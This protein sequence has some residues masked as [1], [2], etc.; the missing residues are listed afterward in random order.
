M[1]SK[2]SDIEKFEM[3]WGK[4]PMFFIAIFFVGGIVIS[5]YIDFDLL[6]LLFFT[7][8]YFIFIFWLEKKWWVS[9]NLLFYKGLA[10]S[11]GILLVGTLR[12]EIDKPIHS[13]YHVLNIIDHNE[14]NI[15]ISGLVTQI[16]QSAKSWKVFVN[17][18]EICQK[19]C[20]KKKTKTIVY[21]Q[22]DHDL[23]VLD[24]VTFRGSILPKRPPNFKAFD[25]NQYLERQGIYFTL[26]VKASTISIQKEGVGNKVKNFVPAFKA[27]LIANIEKSI[28]NTLIQALCKAMFLGDR[29]DVDDDTI[30][31]FSHTGA[32]HILAVSGLH[33]AII[34]GFFVWLLSLVKI[35][36]PW[37]N[38][39][40]KTLVIGGTLLFIFLVGATSSV[41]RAGLLFILLYVTRDNLDKL[42]SLNTLGLVAIILL[43]I[44]PKQVLTLSFQF[45]FTAVLSILLFNEWVKGLITFKSNFLTNLWSYFAVSISVQILM[46]PIIMYYFGFYTTW[47]FLNTI[48]AIP[49]VYI[50]IFGGLIISVSTFFSTYFAVLIG[51]LTTILMGLCYDGL[52]L[53]NSLPYGLIDKISLTTVDLILVYA[54]IGF[55]FLFL[56]FKQKI[57]FKLI[58]STFFLLLISL[59]FTSFQNSTSSEVVFYSVSKGFLIDIFDGNKLYAFKN[60]QLD[61]TSEEYSC[62]AYRRSKRAKEPTYI[63]IDSTSHIGNVLTGENI[64]I[65]RGKKFIKM[66]PND[67]RDLRLVDVVIIGGNVWKKDLQLLDKFSGNVILL[68]EVKFG[69]R[70]EISSLEKQNFILTDLAEIGSYK[71][72]L[73]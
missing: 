72:T 60:D 37:W 19:E 18:A 49:M 62:S 71:I 3:D 61:Q 67:V 63:S 24:K 11:I 40:N 44:N 5:G 13:R 22:G 10:V 6:P 23:K 16:E 29:S 14:K 46:A 39:V 51:K 2:F 25:Y 26:F 57:H 34:M 35:K 66:I 54:A 65:F 33:V 73:R 41:R 21:I 47:F 70:Q 42:K 52:D 38:I 17:V 69:V 15:Q 55:I 31:L 64:F 56:K 20:F 59:S 27:R 48:V 12:H 8:L 43:L 58:T 50:G 68:N 30:K 28:P 53:I 4:Y 1:T 45:S 7:I 36:A 9:V 32:I